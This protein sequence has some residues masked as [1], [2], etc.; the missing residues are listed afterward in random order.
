V[1]QGVL[2]R[3]QFWAPMEFFAY[4]L[5]SLTKICIY[6]GLTNNMGRRFEEHNNGYEKT[7]KPYR[8][9]V[10]I[11]KETFPTRQLAREKEKFLQST[12]GKR[13]LKGLT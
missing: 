4:A 7:T 1:P 6:V 11:Y 5:K 10:L 2:V 3:V 8:P 12:I 9:F 13:F